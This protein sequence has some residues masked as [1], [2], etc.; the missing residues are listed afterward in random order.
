MARGCKVSTVIIAD[1]TSQK[2]AGDHSDEA[3]DVNDQNAVAGMTEPPHG[4]D[5]DVEEDDRRA[6]ESHCT[7]PKRILYNEKRICNI[8]LDSWNNGHEHLQC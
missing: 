5:S 3:N 8:S 6:D 7:E 4:E 2:I 1:D